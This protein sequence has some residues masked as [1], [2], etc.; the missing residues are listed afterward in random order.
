[1][2]GTLGHGVDDPVVRAGLRYLAAEQR[3]W[4]SWYGRWGVNHVYGTW[5]VI[6]ALTALGCGGPHLPR[7]VDWLFRVQN[8]DGGWGE[9]CHSYEDESFAGVGV[10]TPSQTAWAV[11]A[12][13]RSGHGAH[14]SCR[15][16]LD[17]LRERQAGGTWAELEYTGTGFPGDFYINYGMYRHLFPTMALALAGDLR[18]GAGGPTGALDKRAPAVP[19]P[20]A[21]TGVVGRAPRTAGPIGKED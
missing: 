7:A 8:A 19:L 15:R 18:T 6:S 11:M 9:T 20:S 5:C 16:G 21:S 2:L 17:H 14:P 12:L 3:P 10:S 4:G 1:M 13:Q